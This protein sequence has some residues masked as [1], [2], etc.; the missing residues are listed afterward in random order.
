MTNVKKSAGQLQNYRITETGLANCFLSEYLVYQL[1]PF[2][3][4]TLPKLIK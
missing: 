3:A 2:Q 4:Q 1:S